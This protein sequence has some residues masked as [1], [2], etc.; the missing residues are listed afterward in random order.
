MPS[1]IGTAY[2]GQASI[3]SSCERCR[4]Q[5]LKYTGPVGPEGHGPCQRCA[6]AKVDC[7]FGRRRPTS[8]ISEPKRQSEPTTNNLSRATLPSPLTPSTASVTPVVTMANGPSIEPAA[9]STMFDMRGWDSVQLQEVMDKATNF[10]NHL[11]HYDMPPANGLD[12]I[13]LFDIDTENAAPGSS[14][15]Q[16]VQNPPVMT[17]NIC[18]NSDNSGLVQSLLALL[19]EIKIETWIIPNLMSQARRQDRRYAGVTDDPKRPIRRHCKLVLDQAL[20]I[21]DK[22]LFGSIV[23]PLVPVSWVEQWDIGLCC[24][25]RVEYDAKEDGSNEVGEHSAVDWDA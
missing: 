6:R 25:A 10:A 3:R 16:A 14:S 13:F 1:P 24:G 11:D 9:D 2:H 12:D 23:S 22:V 20:G 15:S 17:G 8:Q 5:K 18:G 21:C 19:S 7:V 4:F